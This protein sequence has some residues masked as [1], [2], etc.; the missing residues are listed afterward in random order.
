MRALLLLCLLAVPAVA[1]G[2]VEPS[3]SSPSPV[4]EL[5]VVTP[6]DGSGVDAAGAVGSLTAL[7]A[8][9]VFARSRKT[10]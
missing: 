1:N 6:P 2:G 7:A 5:A 3:A 4:Q 9:F 8:S 10:R